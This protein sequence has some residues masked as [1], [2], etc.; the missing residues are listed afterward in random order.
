MNEGFL[1]TAGQI[2]SADLEAYFLKEKKLSKKSTN[3]ST[4]QALPAPPTPR[5]GGVWVAS[6]RWVA[7]VTVAAS[8]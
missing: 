6:G 8:V 7:T 1:H 4:N 3:V 2:K 5:G